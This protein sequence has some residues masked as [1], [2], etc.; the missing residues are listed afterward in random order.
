MPPGGAL[1]DPVLS[2]G[3]LSVAVPLGDHQG[4]SQGKVGG[5]GAPGAALEGGAAPG[6]TW[7]A[8]PR[9]LSVAACSSLASS[10]RLLAARW[11]AS[12][13]RHLCHTCAKEDSFWELGL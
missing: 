5:V 11:L 4:D 8:R 2:A 10:R 9:V 6:C 7:W 1:L 3:A 13:L 12:W